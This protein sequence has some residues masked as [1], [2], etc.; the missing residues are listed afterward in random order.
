MPL[1]QSPRPGRGFTLIELLVVIAIIAV[2]IA[3][4][5]PAVQSAREAA[6]RAQ[7]VNN[8]KQIGLAMHNY[9]TQMDT[10]PPGYIS[11]TQTSLPNSPETGPG[12]AWGTML[13][14]LLEQQPLY[15][16][17]N[18][19]LQ[20]TDPSSVTVRTTRLAGFLCPSS[21]W[22]TGPITLKNSSGT[23][24]ITDLV[25]GQ[26]VGSAGQWEVEEFAAENNGVFYRNSRIG[27]RNI[28]DGT[29]TTLMA[30]ERSRNVA[31]ST[32]VGV[33]PTAVSCTRPGWPHQDCETANVLVLSH[34]GPSPDEQWVDT[35]NRKTA[36]ADDFWSLH[37]GGC[38]FLFC[39][40]SV[41]FIK[42]T[43]NPHIFSYLSTRAGGEVLS[44]DQF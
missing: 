33:I 40:G 10:F 28:T 19:S 9:H 20:I 2:L 34:T 12:W 37:P 16:T 42:E 29:T 26:Y 18:F 38:N 13:L 30:G 31:D 41:R 1:A 6:R 14:N 32:W 8:L 44:A 15:N 5:L 7:C 43:V 25:A 3:L 4:L 27:V 36:G 39:D 35:P 21:T 24:L 22:D 17:V 11:S 23:V